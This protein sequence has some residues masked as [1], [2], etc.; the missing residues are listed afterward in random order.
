VVVWSKIGDNS[1]V[2]AWLPII[3]QPRLT[4]ARITPAKIRGASI[5]IL[6]RLIFGIYQG[7]LFTNANATTAQ[8]TMQH[9]H[10]TPITIIK[11]IATLL[12]ESIGSLTGFA[13]D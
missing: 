5:F 2:L 12:P 1:V 4:T 7:G 11:A 9:K 6:M 3:W 8:D 10:T 13:G